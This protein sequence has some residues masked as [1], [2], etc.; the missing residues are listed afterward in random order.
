LSGI[1]VH[2]WLA[3]IG[4]S[5]NVFETMAQVFPD[6]ERFCLW[7]ESDGRFTGVAETMLARTPLRGR[8]AA[9]L[10]FM[11]A[12]WRSLPKRDA[13][14]VL[15]SSHL[16]SHHARFAG[17]ARDA[18]KL[19][20]VYTPA[21]YIWVPEMD[22]RGTSAVARA[23]AA[24]LKPLDRRRAQEP[25]AVAGISQFVVDRIASVW[26]RES[27]VIYPPV[28][29][30]AFAGE[31]FP[32]G[33]ALAMLDSLPAEFVFA[34]SR[35][36]EYKRMEAAITVGEAAGLPVVIAGSG[37]DL[38]RL[39]AIAETSRVP[40]IFIGRPGHEALRA[41]YRRASVLVFAAVEDFGIVPV[42][43][44]ASGT[45]VIASAIGGAAET[46]VDGV[47]GALVREWRSPDDVGI[48][49]ATALD[50]SAE[51]CVKRAQEFSIPVFSRRLRSW[52]EAH[53]GDGSSTGERAHSRAS[54]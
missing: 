46:V 42:E 2:E 32:D 22:G 44:M 20:Y 12:V 48:A 4:G 5:E 28:D 21:R 52:V 50:A 18:P 41:L 7:N 16:F 3:P 43:A 8:K 47:T 15:S 51:N 30:D 45:P 29:V 38:A 27:E 13:D 34:V 49:V 40:V 17:P 33:D 25:A 53:V 10:P 26:D 54:Q 1:L 11:P 39:T 14:W 6:A 35:L 23:I 36:I 9:A 24:P 37:P 19:A 31:P